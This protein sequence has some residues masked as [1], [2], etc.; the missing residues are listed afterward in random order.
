MK[1]LLR[2]SLKT[3]YCN[4]KYMFEDLFMQCI[5]CMIGSYG[6]KHSNQTIIL[7]F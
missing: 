4:Q 6:T 2:V 3:G 5:N 1:H 7:K